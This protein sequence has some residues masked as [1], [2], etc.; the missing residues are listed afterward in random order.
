M[1][2]PDGQAWTI[3]PSGVNLNNG[4]GGRDIGFNQLTYPN[5]GNPVGL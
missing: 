2:S 1:T 4:A 5:P 3:V